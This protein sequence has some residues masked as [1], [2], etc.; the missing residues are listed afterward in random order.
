MFAPWAQWQ[1]I[2]HFV[3][4]TALFAQ[5]QHAITFERNGV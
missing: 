4:Q 5:L 3:P 2:G 1:E